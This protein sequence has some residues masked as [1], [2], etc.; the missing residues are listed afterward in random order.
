MKALVE[1]V[2]ALANLI[3]RYD[4]WWKAE[5]LDLISLIFHILK[6]RV[7]SYRDLR[8]A[9]TLTL[10]YPSQLCSLRVATPSSR[11]L[12]YRTVPDGRAAL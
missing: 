7:I 8:V 11:L 2:E 4:E 6:N 9:C 3:G 10:V 5:H 12:F 1:Y